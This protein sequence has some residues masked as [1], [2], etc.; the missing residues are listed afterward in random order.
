MKTD[1]EKIISALK[2]FIKKLARIRIQYNQIIN[3]QNAKPK[4]KY[5]ES[6]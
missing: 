6:I 5:Q 2:Y 4:S 1:D 3:S